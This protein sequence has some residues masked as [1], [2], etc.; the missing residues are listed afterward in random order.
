MSA[1]RL[2][3]W[4]LLRVVAAVVA[5]PDLWLIAVRQLWLLVPAGWWRRAPYLPVPDAAYLRFRLLTAYGD[6]ERPPDAE[7]VVTYLEW[8]RSFDELNPPAGERARG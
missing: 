1:P 5:R 7:D 2:R 4:M 8:A 6:P 3:W